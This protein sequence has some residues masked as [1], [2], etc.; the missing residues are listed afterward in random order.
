MLENNKVQKKRVNW[1]IKRV[2]NISEE[3]KVYM[4]SQNP[5]HSQTIIQ[6]TLYK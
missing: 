6:G 5:K 1:R 3:N 4:P 2:L